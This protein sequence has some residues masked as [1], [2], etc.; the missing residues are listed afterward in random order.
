MTLRAIDIDRTIRQ[1]VL[2]KWSRG[3]F[4]E[5]LWRL[6]AKRHRGQRL[7]CLPLHGHFK[8]SLHL[9]LLFHDHRL[10]R[11]IGIKLLLQ[12]HLLL[13]HHHLLI[14]LHLLLHFGRR[15]ILLLLKSLHLLLLL[16]RHHFYWHCHA[17]SWLHRLAC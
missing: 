3:L 11:L 1:L 15:L 5:R 13:L 9:Q 4:D 17:H 6:L 7:H 16:R 8:R 12:H 14:L 2:I 10:H